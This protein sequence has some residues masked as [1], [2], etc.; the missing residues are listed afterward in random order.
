MARTTATAVIFLMVLSALP[1]AAQGIEYPL[2]DK[3]NF[4]LE[5]SAVGMKT[6]IRFGS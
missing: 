5:G 2:F 1:A 4:M 6:K 3:F